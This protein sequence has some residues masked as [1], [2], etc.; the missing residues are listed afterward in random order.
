M[1]VY[2]DFLREAI[3]SFFFPPV[4]TCCAALLA[5]SAGLLCPACQS[6]VWTLTRDDPLF[7]LAHQRLCGDGLCADVVS[8]YRFEKNGPVQALMHALKYRGGTL[9][10]RRLG[11]LLGQ[12]VSQRMWTPT[13]EVI[14]PLPLHRARLRERGYNQSELF[15]R[16]IADVLGLPISTSGVRRTRWTHSQTKLGYAERR[17]NVQSAF[18]ISPLKRGVLQGRKVLLVDDVITTGATIRACATALVEETGCTVFA[19]SIALADQ[20]P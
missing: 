13:I 5:S 16:G 17:E 15:A 8:A 19:A 2:R 10:G 9:V 6:R 12:L 7:S 18:E 4:C 3:L 1:P 20:D 14:V 11:A